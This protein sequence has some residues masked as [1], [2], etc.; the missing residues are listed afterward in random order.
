MASRSSPSHV[1]PLPLAM[2]FGMALLAL[3]LVAGARLAGF[4]PQQAVSSGEVRESRL[5]SF[6][7]DG[8]G[9][10]AVIDAQ[11]G[12]TITLAGKEGFIP[13]VLRGLNR[14]RRTNEFHPGDAYR[15]ERLSSGELMLV[16]TTTGVR[17]ELNAYGHANAR[18]FETFLRPTG[19]K[20]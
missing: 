8:R 16:D 5:L 18:V 10:V 2:S 4:T 17:L 6:Q 13:G 15:L 20:S 19:D 11:T 14:L 12:E 1:P 7:T 3:C 9:D